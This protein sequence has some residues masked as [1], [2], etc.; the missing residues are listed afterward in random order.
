[1]RINFP[2]AAG[3]NGDAM[4]QGDPSRHAREMASSFY[5]LF[6]EGRADAAFF[7]FT[8]SCMIAGGKGDTLRSRA[9]GVSRYQAPAT[10]KQASNVRFFQ[11]KG[12]L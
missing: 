9:F 4:P 11:L 12:R 8:G 3:V 10:G 7:C 5:T 6:R 2:A 1:M